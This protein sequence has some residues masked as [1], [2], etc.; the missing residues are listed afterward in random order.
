MHERILVFV[1]PHLNSNGAEYSPCAIAE[2]SMIVP[3][4]LPNRLFYKRFFPFLFPI[5]LE[6]G[7]VDSVVHSRFQN[8]KTSLFAK[9]K[10]IT[11]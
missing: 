2:S 6:S 10:D 1:Y 4:S 3:F 8:S 5:G 11:Q 9:T 7:T